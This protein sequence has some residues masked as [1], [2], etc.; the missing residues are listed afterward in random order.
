MTFRAG[1][2][3]LRS[4]RELVPNLAWAGELVRQ[5]AAQGAHYVLTPEV[6][7]VFEPDKELLKATALAEADDPCVF[8]FSV[9]AHELGIYLH[10]GSVALKGNDGK[11]INRSI[12][13]GPDGKKIAHYDTIHLFDIDLPSGESYRESH[14]YTPGGDAVVVTLP[15]ATLGFSICYD[16]RFPQLFNTLALGGA[17]VIVVPAAFTAPTGEAH[18]HVLLRARAIET[19]SYVLAAAQGGVHDSGRATY[20][21]SLAIDPW[22]AIV[23]EAGTDPGVLV[24]DVEPEKSAL[25]RGRIPAL[26]N[27]RSFGLKQVQG[28]ARSLP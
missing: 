11:L 19:G 8:G 16:V 3:Q 23:A 13:F 4:S 22:G 17:N 1:L 28:A 25:A 24:F 18:W 12:L 26:Q 6:T 7:N 27:A 5:A 10:I 2:V 9:L 20:G 14:S 15:F 21:H